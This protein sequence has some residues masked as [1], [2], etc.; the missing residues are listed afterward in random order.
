MASI[1]L[2]VTAL[3]FRISVKE[4]NTLV[5]HRH[6]TGGDINV[7]RLSFDGCRARSDLI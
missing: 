6:I 2:V 1:F 3:Y 7:T 4:H 5:K